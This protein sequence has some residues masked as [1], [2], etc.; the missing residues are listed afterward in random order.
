VG[1]VCWAIDFFFQVIMQVITIGRWVLRYDPEATRSAFSLVR[2]GA[3]ESCGCRDCLNFVAARNQA[4]PSQAS[5]TFDQLGIDSHKESE[6][7]HAHRDK[8][9]LHHYGGFFHFV[10]AIE[11]GK[12]AMQM[13]NGH[14]TYDLEP[15]ADQFEFGFT[16]EA[17]LVPESFAGVQVVQLEFQTKIPWMLNLPESD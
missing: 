10:G 9:G 7:W 8:S 17:G 12:D 6:I 1:R 14:G 15:I 13:V 4:Y 3:P 16:S 11:S 2:T 5:A